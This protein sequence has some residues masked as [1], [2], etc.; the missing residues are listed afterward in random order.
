MDKR[1]IRG[2]VI[3]SYLSFIKMKWGRFGKEECLKEIGINDKIK[4]GKYYPHKIKVSILNWI[5]KNKGEKYIEVAGKYLIGNLGHLSWIV[6]HDTPFKI[7]KKIEEEYEEIYDF[8]ELIVTGT[9]GNIEVHLKK[10]ENDELICL[11]FKGILEGILE[12][13]NKHGSIIIQNSEEGVCEYHIK[14]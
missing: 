3:N 6:R 13:T 4:D 7:T 10:P 14:Y 8:G 11:T 2:C 9:E 5:K 1:K 12:S